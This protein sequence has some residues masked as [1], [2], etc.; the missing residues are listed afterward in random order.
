VVAH[1]LLDV[2]VLLALAWP[3]H[4]HHGEAHR[5]FQQHRHKGFATCPLT[6]LGFVRS[7]SNPKFTKDA[8]PPATA[9]ELLD[10]LTRLPEHSFWP[11]VLSCKEALAGDQLIVG[12]RQLTDL[13]LLGL[14]HGNSGV[15]ATFDRSIPNA[16]I[17]GQPETPEQLTRTPRG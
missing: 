17:I 15:L 8:V 14:A 4:M 16:E 9:L 10:R 2:N 3:N 1:Y 11:D 13:Y 5:W 6:Q 12:H 7:S